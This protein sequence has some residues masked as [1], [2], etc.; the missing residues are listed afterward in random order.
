MANG[1]TCKVQHDS[2]S[3]TLSNTAD[4][5]PHRPRSFVTC[6]PPGVWPPINGGGLEW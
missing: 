1:W 3:N 4:R 5:C 6:G 2:D